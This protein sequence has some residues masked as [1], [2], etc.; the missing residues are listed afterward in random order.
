MERESR[1]KMGVD[2]RFLITEDRYVNTLGSGHL[3]ERARC[4]LYIA[5]EGDCQTFG[6]VLE[7]FVMEIQRYQQPAREPGIV[8]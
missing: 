6:D 5:D 1:D 4:R 7:I 8:I 2:V 3:P